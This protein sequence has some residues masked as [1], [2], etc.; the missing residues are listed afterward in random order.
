MSPHLERIH[1]DIR[2]WIA[3]L[4]KPQTKL[5]KFPVCPFAKS[6]V[7][8]GSIRIVIH[9]TGCLESYLRGIIDA[10]KH[11]PLQVLVCVDLQDHSREGLDHICDR[12][13]RWSMLPKTDLVLLADHPDE[14][15][16]LNGVQTSQGCYRM[17]L[18]QRLSELNDHSD[19]LQKTNY[20]SV[21]TKDNLKRV[22]E[23]RQPS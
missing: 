8:S 20:Y 21:W 1:K 11:D 2:E 13:N 17:V 9:S 12:I 15:F 14:P 10:W 23:W 16:F 18:I 22:V 3:F 4:Q 19:S 6:A 5:N 7:K